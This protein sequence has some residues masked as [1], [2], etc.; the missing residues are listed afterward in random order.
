MKHRV[1]NIQFKVF[2]NGA[3][4]CRISE[5]P[6]ASERHLI[7]QAKT[8]ITPRPRDSFTFQHR[9][10]TKPQFRNPTDPLP[11]SR[12]SENGR[13]VDGLPTGKRLSN[14]LK[15]IIPYEVIFGQPSVSD[16]EYAER[17]EKIR[18]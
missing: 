16:E 14:L 7:E 8:F 6:E 10:I 11:Y 2:L 15:N 9:S 5:Y 3:E 17:L 4:I 18:Y 12:Y 13:W 1:A